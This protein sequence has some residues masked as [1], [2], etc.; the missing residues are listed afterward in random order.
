[1]VTAGCRDA[2]SFHAGRT[3]ADDHDIFSF[4]DR[5][6]FVGCRAAFAHDPLRHRIDAAV[7]RHSIGFIASDMAVQTA[8][9]R[10]N[11]IKPVFF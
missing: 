9:T 5:R 7:S 8:R 11:F 3:A 10:R 4:F 6:Q 1:M 2:G